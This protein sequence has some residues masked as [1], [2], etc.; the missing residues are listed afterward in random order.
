MACLNRK[1][2]IGEKMEKCILTAYCK[3]PFPK[4][5]KEKLGV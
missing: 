3:L 2:V 1:F 4:E 5:K